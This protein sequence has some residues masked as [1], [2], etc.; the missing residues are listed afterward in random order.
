MEAKQWVWP[1]WVVHFSSSNMKDKACSGWPHTAVTP[2]NEEHL[3][4]L[5]HTNLLMMAIMLKNS[6]L[7]LRN[8]A[9]K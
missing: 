4:Q 9:N 7:Q 8:C 6:V 1:Q 5:I 3:Y 2:Q